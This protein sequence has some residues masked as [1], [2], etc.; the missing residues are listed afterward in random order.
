MRSVYLHGNP[1]GPG[2]LQLLGGEA[3]ASWLAP[4]RAILPL[5][6]EA[7][8]TALAE[9]I[10]DASSDEPVRLVGFSAGAHVALQLAARMPEA[11]MVLHLVSPAG[12][13]ELGEFLDSMAGG[14]VFRAAM[15]HPRLFSA[16][17]R[18]QAIGARAF[19]RQLMRMLFAT[20][21]GEDSALL[22]DRQFNRGY[23]TVLQHCLI[24]GR[25]SYQ[26]EI[27]AYV[28]PWAGLLSD[29]RHPVT[30]W[31]GSRDNWTPP[32]MAEAMARK[33]PQVKAINLLEGQSHF[34][35]LR[36][37]LAALA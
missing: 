11:D 30:I 25:A 6:P 33:L 7:R 21:Q 13:L 14:P 29:V 5:E 9:M 17:V 37:A 31:Q 19:P 24:A 3:V 22:E 35:A 4:D 12:P 20:A 36:T 2:E 34:S 18:A 27:E 26:A 16:L 1:G 32:E 23:Q 28:R 8:L 10:A 15:K